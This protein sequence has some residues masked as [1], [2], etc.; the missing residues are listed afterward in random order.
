M[1]GG[2]L[3]VSTNRRP[4]V[5]IQ[6]VP[7]VIYTTSGVSSKKVE[8]G[9]FSEENT[10]V[11][12]IVAGPRVRRHGTRAVDLRQVAPTILKALDLEPEGPAG[13]PA[14]GHA[15]A[16]QGPPHDDCDDDDDD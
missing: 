7:G 12:L 10:H 9:G 6:P 4:D 13:R 2:T 5:I 11:P 14:R 3:D 1:F 16:A 8:H 15:G